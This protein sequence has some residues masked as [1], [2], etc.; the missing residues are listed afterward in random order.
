M[1]ERAGERY[2]F[3][4]DFPLF[5]GT[6]FGISEEVVY[7]LQVSTANYGFQ[8]PLPLGYSITHSLILIRSQLIP[9]VY[10]RVGIFCQTNSDEVAQWYQGA[11]DTIL[12][13]V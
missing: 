6:D 9:D 10:E 13:I 11:E 5:E 3:Q 1:L 7:C 4:P 2:A 8:P 12:T